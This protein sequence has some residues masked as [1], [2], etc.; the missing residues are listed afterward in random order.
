VPRLTAER[1]GMEREEMEM[2]RD[3]YVLGLTTKGH[4]LLSQRMVVFPVIDGDDDERIPSGARALQVFAD[5]KRA[6]EYLGRE[7]PERTRKFT[8]ETVEELRD[9]SISYMKRHEVRATARTLG[10]NYI[11]VEHADGRFTVDDVVDD[12]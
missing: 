2:G 4:F 9:F 6:A 10:A 1:R 11:L 3:Y 5:H 8:E 7:M 12:V